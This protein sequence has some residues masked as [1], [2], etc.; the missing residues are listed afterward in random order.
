MFPTQRWLRLSALM[1]IASFIMAACGSAP[2]TT[3][4]PAAA[5]AAPAA[6]ATSAPAAEATSAP[7]AAT[8][9]PAGDAG[10]ATGKK[11][12]VFSWWT[13]TGEA[14]GKEAM[15]EIF[16][17]QN[18][19]IEI[20]D[21]AVSGGAGANAKTVLATR[22]SGNNP[23]D[24]FQV[25][26]GQEVIDTW[27]RTDKI[28]PLTQFFKDNGLDK[29][30]PP[31]LLEQISDGGEIWTVPVNIH[32]S[33][34][35]WYN[36]KIFADN[37]LT[38]PKTI[39]DFM[40]VAETLKGKGITPLA[41]G[42]KDT[43]ATPHL[44]E[45]ILLATYGDDYAKMFNDPTLLADARLATSIEVLGK[46]LG[47]SNADRT[48]LSWQDAAQ[49]L[50][51]GKAAMTIMG[52]WAE[53]YFK[54]QGW[55]PNVEFGWAPS[56]GTDGYFLWLSDSFPLPK[57]APNREAA[58]AWLKVASSKEGQDAF[59]PQ[60]GSIPARTDADKSKYD[61][62][63]QYSIE[64]FATNKLAP[65]IEHG[66]AAPTAFVTEFENAVNV[67]ASDN[68]AADFTAN[69]AQAVAELVK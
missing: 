6:A 18:P 64:Q 48:S 68:N 44:Y 52:D 42:G 29:V 37:N 4:A 2:A 45:S 24:S 49:Q 41:I 8:S 40:K 14:E 20:V 35:L 7:A 60:K 21:A 66:A 55:K 63:L 43:F 56:P 16:R 46:M 12:E 51:D 39:D 53:G 1:V 36:K 15:Y 11:L 25:H 61:E 47:Y 13:G 27:A 57:G 62:Y 10:A 17:K 50:V 59:N 58:L 65:S 38:A 69:I 26:A 31:L 9:A 32:R 33:N 28:E 3:T 54:T 30:M 19:G 22:M 67:F 5:T 34:V 23:P